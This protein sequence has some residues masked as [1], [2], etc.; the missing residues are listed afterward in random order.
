[1][2][3]LHKFFEKIQFCLVIHVNL[4]YNY[5]SRCRYS[6]YSFLLSYNF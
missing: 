1:M 4:L 2:I 3:I 5:R 6:Y